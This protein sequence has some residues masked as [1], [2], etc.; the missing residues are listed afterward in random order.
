MSWNVDVFSK[1]GSHLPLA[2]CLHHLRHAGNAAVVR[3]RVS[4]GR[5]GPC[6]DVREVERDL[7]HGLVVEDPPDDKLLVKL[8]G[9]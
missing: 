2:V 3:R 9:S 4:Q 7:H 8:P 1:Y 6:R 5:I